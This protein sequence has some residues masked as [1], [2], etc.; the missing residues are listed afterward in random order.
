MLLDLSVDLALAA[1]LFEIYA[2]NL[3]MSDAP[4]ERQRRHR[5]IVTERP[6]TKAER[7]ESVPPIR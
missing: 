4:A 6:I 5:D 1:G 7:E 3:L 2:F